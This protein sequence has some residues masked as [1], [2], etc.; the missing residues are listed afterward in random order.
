MVF[1]LKHPVFIIP[2]KVCSQSLKTQKTDLLFWMSLT[3]SCF[4]FVV[5][6]R[7][8]GLTCTRCTLFQLCHLHVAK[9]LAARPASRSWNWL[10]ERRCPQRGVLQR[11][12]IGVEPRYHWLEVMESF[13]VETKLAKHSCSGNA[14]VIYMCLLKI[15]FGAGIRQFGMSKHDPRTYFFFK[16]FIGPPPVVTTS[17]GRSASTSRS[18]GTSS[19][20]D[21]TTTTITTT[22]TTSTTTTTTSTSTSTIASSI[23]TWR[24]PLTRN[25]GTYMWLFPAIY[26][27]PPPKKKRNSYFC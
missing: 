14:C 23:T 10:P 12:A 15:H 1:F 21:T 17:T 26:P 3:P 8:P 16:I 19:S 7:F 4:F 9:P 2:E 18:R 13:F 27:S 24:R 11:G 5:A 6:K 22:T 25:K 20:N